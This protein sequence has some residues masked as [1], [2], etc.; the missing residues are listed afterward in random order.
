[1]S[2]VSAIAPAGAASRREVWGLGLLF[3]AFYFI[4][5]L[6]EPTESLV[7]QPMQSWLD[8]WGYDTAA[9]GVFMFIMATP[10]FI[11]PVFGLLTDFVPLFGSRRRNYFLLATAVA[12]IGLGYVSLFQPEA[13]EANRLL[14]CVV[15]ATFGVAF[16][17]VVTDALMVEK[18]QPRG[19]TG[20][21][22][23]VQW[24]AMNVAAMLAGWLGGRLSG[25]EKQHYAF[26]I[27]AILMSLNAGLVFTFVRDDPRV[28]PKSHPGVKD[29]WR[30]ATQPLMLGVAAF[31][32]LWSFN[33]FSNNVLYVFMRKGLEFSN[34]F[35]GWTNT[36]MAIGFVLGSM[37]YG[38]Y[39]R[40]VSW[41]WLLHLSIVAGIL[42]TIAYWWMETETSALIVS[43]MVGFTYMT[44]NLIGMDLAARI[45]PPAMAGTLFAM[46]MAASN[47]SLQLAT[48]LG[49][50]L[51]EWWRPQLGE[52]M[53]F[54]IL[55]AVGAVF[56]AACWLLMP[57]L[58][59][60][61]Y[62]LAEAS[63]REEMS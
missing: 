17:D 13:H 25:I 6:A 39:C 61:P 49:G 22:Q 63:V 30:A 55:V 12:A 35:Y 48:L 10:W 51:Y 47:L 44:G 60:A 42:N 53:A 57:I 27:C 5:G 26:L 33:P 21:L 1:V 20:V 38:L 3:G 34:E 43:A 8:R 41:T 23:S 24:T 16:A 31:L 36:Y 15:I 56:T 28:G 4:Q 9:M 2:D 14:A 29:L 11:K 7:K 32:V 62:A 59:R 52:R 58:R 54:D 46:L 18:G 45:C 19:V 50:Y 40:R 37:T